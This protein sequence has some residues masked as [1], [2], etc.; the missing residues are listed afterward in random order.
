[1][2]FHDAKLWKA[3]I[4]RQQDGAAGGTEVAEFIKSGKRRVK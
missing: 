3:I 1:M 4:L 2:T